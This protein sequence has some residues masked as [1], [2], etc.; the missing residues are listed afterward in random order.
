LTGKS[1]DA[2]DK[3]RNKVPYLVTLNLIAGVIVYYQYYAFLFIKI[4]G[5]QII[6][7]VQNSV[8]RMKKFN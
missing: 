5:F 4:V 6:T 2:S 1:K 7:L 3:S 8:S